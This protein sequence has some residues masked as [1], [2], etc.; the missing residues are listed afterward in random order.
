MKRKGLLALLLVTLMSCDIRIVVDHTRPSEATPSLPSSPTSET[1]PSLTPT[2]SEE[3]PSSLPTISTPTISGEISESPSLPIPSETPSVPSPSVE[4]GIPEGEQRQIDIYC[5]NDFHGATDYRLNKINTSIYQ[6]GIS[7][8]AQFLED[9]KAENPDGTFVVSAGDM[10]QGGYVSSASHGDFLTQA[11]NQMEF[12]CMALG[13]HEFDWGEESIA[14]NLQTA[15]FPFLGANIYYANGNRPQWVENQTTITK[16]DVK[17]A[18]I[19]TIGDTQESSILSSISANFDFRDEESAMREQAN[20]AKEQGADLVISLSHN[21]WRDY[22]KDSAQNAI[23]QESVVDG[24]F[25]GHSHSLQ[26]TSVNGIP[27]LQAYSSGTSVAHM[28]FTVK[29][30]GG[31]ISKEVSKYEVCNYLA[32]TYKNKPNAMMEQFYENYIQE[33]GYEAGMKEVLT[34]IS[35]DWSTAEVGRISAEAMRTY[36]ASHALNGVNYDAVL[37]VQN[38]AGV[39]AF[40]ENGEVTYADIYEAFPFDNVVVLIS[41]TASRMEQYYTTVSSTSA[42]YYYYSSSQ[43]SFPSSGEPYYM[44]TMDY[45]EGTR[46]FPHNDSDVIRSTVLQRDVIKEYLKN[47][48]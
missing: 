40:I 35:K 9:K 26:N 28:R 7:R 30:E 3:E 38:T 12:D 20:L 15:N 14:A 11:M 19:G 32:D 5:L 48:G 46:Y 2:P 25:S 29:N 33:N 37:G 34:T 1:I 16:N 45:V 47:I 44:A 24:I 43:T 17:V 36:F 4:E 42:S 27:V 31:M 8:L 18:F 21:D 39:R 23:L 13:N 22:A 41:A 6:L 10:W